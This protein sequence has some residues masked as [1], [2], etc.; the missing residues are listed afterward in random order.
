MRA[1]CADVLLEKP[2]GVGVGDHDPRRLFV[3]QTLH[4][5]GGDNPPFIRRDR[6]G[7]VAAQGGAG[8]IGSVRR[9]G[10]ED[11]RPLLSPAPMPGMDDQHPRQL[12]LGAGRR[13]ER[14]RIEARD[15]GEV[16]LQS[17][18]QAKRPL[19]EGGG[20]ERMGR[21]EP[22]ERRLPF[23]GLRVVLHRAGAERVEARVHPVIPGGE[24]GV[25]AHHLDFAEIGEIGPVARERRGQGA[26]RHIPR[27]QGK[28]APPLFPPL[29][30]ER[31]IERERGLHHRLGHDFTSLTRTSI[32]SRLAVSV[33]H[34]SE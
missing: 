5:A 7:G 29:P 2:Q 33:T 13:L 22:L 21:G 16:P 24:A 32:S 19:G 17:E 12:P 30:E 3:H 10:D 15:L 28:A 11:L 27:R 6:H 18:H 8:R 23:I 26:L 1:I 20:Q 34:I 14:H 25:V 9:V 31:F 4:D